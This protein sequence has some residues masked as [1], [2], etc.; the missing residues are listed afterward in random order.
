VL[1]LPSH[2]PC[3]VLALISPC[4]LALAIRGFGHPKH[5][6]IH[7]LIVDTSAMMRF[8]LN[9]L[10]GLTLVVHVLA[11]ATATVSIQPEHVIGTKCPATDLV[12]RRGLSIVM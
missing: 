5:V 6:R 8:I 7:I 2:K 11:E 3:K 1:T 10:T 4:G 9:I 12:E